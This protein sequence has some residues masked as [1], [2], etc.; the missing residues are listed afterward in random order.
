MRL[1]KTVAD[2]VAAIASNSRVFVHAGAA[3]PTALIEGVVARAGELKNVEFTHLPQLVGNV[4]FMDTKYRGTFSVSTFFVG[5]N[6]RPVFEPGMFDYIP[7][8][9]SEIPSLFRSTHFPLDVAL[10]HVSPPDAHGF[11]SLGTNVDIARAAADVA[12]TV[13]VQ[14]NPKMPRVLGDALVHVNNI[15]HAVEVNDDIHE[16][17]WK[18][19]SEEEHS[20]VNHVASLIDD[21]ATLHT[22]IGHVPDAILGTHYFVFIFINGRVW[23]YRNVLLMIFQV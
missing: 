3:T 18:P 5:S 19:L 4:P 11:C 10:L 23:R 16:F 22:G 6:M 12:K 2:A 20:L 15:H 8:F 13:I 21:G 1:H 17:K 14:I 9:S 7:C